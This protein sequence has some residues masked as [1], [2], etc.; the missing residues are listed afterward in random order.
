MAESEF[1]WIGIGAEQYVAAKPN[2]LLDLTLNFRRTRAS[3]PALQLRQQFQ[4]SLGKPFSSR[5]L[6]NYNY[7]KPAVIIG[8]EGR[9]AAGQG[10]GRQHLLVTRLKFTER[11]RSTFSTTLLDGNFTVCMTGLKN[12]FAFTPAIPLLSKEIIQRG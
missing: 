5:P 11:P 10:I 8:F 12:T 6:F 2:C 7:R 1:A 3:P 9:S 4:W